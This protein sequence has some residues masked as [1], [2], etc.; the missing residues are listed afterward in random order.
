MFFSFLFRLFSPLQSKEVSSLSVEPAPGL[1]PQRSCAQENQTQ[2]NRILNY[3]WCIVLDLSVLIRT[4]TGL[5]HVCTV[6]DLACTVLG[7]AV[8][9]FAVLL[10]RTLVYH[11]KYFG[12]NT[13]RTGAKATRSWSQPSTS[14]QVAP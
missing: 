8:L 3:S 9:A 11:A 4:A 5:C 6:L 2:K 14:P 7:F 10:P 13:S 1:R 12:T